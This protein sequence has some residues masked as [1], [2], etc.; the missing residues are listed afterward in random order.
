MKHKTLGIIA[1][2][3]AALLTGCAGQ[4]ATYDSIEDL[5][6]AF[7]DAGGNCPEFSVTDPSDLATSSARCS[8][9]TVIAIYPDHDAV[10]AQID[11]VKGSGLSGL[12]GDSTRLIGENWMIN[13]PDLEQ[14][15]K[16][17]GGEIVSTAP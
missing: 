1:L 16:E 6:D 4:N 2:A 9:S 11:K 15:Q 10:L 12:I 17:L 3:S 13:A 7:V 14:I 8:S 5:R